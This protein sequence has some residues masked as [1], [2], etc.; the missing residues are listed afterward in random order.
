MYLSQRKERP[1]LCG[2]F[3][4][5]GTRPPPVCQRQTCRLRRPNRCQ[6]D[7]PWLLDTPAAAAPTE[8]QTAATTTASSTQLQ[9]E[10]QRKQKE[11]RQRRSTGNVGSTMHYARVCVYPPLRHHHHHHGP[12]VQDF[13]SD[14]SKRPFRAWYAYI[15]PVRAWYYNKQCSAKRFR[16]VPV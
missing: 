8:K 3:H 6:C 15:L 4:I 11:H 10:Q 16:D 9:H 2:L 1:P 13:G 14:G 12:R 5:V 7:N